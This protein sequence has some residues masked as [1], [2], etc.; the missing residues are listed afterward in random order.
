MVESRWANDWEREKRGAGVYVV[1]LSVRL[2]FFPLQM[3]RACAVIYMSVCVSRKE[4]L[5][6]VCLAFFLAV[7]ALVV[8]L[9]A[10]VL[11]VTIVF[12]IAKKRR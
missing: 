9:S 1:R 2:L 10:L 8:F 7:R 3:P 5:D 11:V 4:R 6:G 12:C